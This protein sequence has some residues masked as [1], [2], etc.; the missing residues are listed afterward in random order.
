MRKLP[1]LLLLLLLPFIAERVFAQDI[2][3][4]IQTL[5]AYL[6]ENLQSK[7]NMPGIPETGMAVLRQQLVLAEAI[8]TWLESLKR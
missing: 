6:N 2:E 1:L 5:K 3:R 7:E 4:N 8:E